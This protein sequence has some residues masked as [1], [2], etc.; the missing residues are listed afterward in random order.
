MHTVTRQHQWPE[1]D[2]VVEISE[3]DINYAN[4][5][6]LVDKYDGEMGEYEDP[7]EAVET[8]ITIAQ[9]WQV[10]DKDKI[11]LIA[12]GG[13]GGMT[14]PFE[15][16]P[17]N[18][19]TFAGLREWAKKLWEEIDKC[20][21]CQAVLGKERYALD[22]FH[23]NEMEF[24]YCSSNCAENAK[25]DILKEEHDQIVKAHPNGCPDCGE[26]LPDD[27]VNGTDCPECNYTYCL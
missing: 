6:A 17:L 5:G 23:A 1:G 9:Q 22:D 7:R 10:D 2:F 13:T 4:P 14:M 21:R 11:V 3:G 12:H 16:E 24:D 25:A 26:D 20:H 27:V 8:A 19:D 18:E 15:G